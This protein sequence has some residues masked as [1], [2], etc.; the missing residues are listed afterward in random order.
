MNFHIQLLD[1][2]VPVAT[3]TFLP[4]IFVDYIITMYSIKQSTFILYNVIHGGS[5]LHG[6]IPFY[7]L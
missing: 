3:S 6:V 4:G 2:D 1:L 7:Q 5:L